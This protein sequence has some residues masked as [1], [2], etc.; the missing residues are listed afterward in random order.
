MLAAAWHFWFN[1]DPPPSWEEAVGVYVGTYQGYVDR[2]ELKKRSRVH[3]DP[4]NPE[5]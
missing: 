3:S 4:E 2:V 5:W 1:H